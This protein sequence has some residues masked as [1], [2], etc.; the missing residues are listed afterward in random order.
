[1][2]PHPKTIVLVAVAAGML[3]GAYLLAPSNAPA[4]TASPAITQ[5]VPRP[6]AAVAMAPASKMASYV[7]T[8]QAPVPLVVGKHDK[9][10]DATPAPEA[11]SN[12]TQPAP[13]T[14]DVQQALTAPN[15]S[16]AKASIELDGYK[17]VRGLVQTPDG[18]W[19][20]RAMRGRTEI[21]VSV[22]PDGSVSQD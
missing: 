2:K 15:D 20:G 19:H 16:A 4:A 9:Y 8:F 22:T 14:G 5:A 10:F 21:A 18:V 1:M 13:A 6:A 17:N 12:P 3:T 11:A 7:K